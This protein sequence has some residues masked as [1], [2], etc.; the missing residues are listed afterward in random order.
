MIPGPC[1]FADAA[2]ALV[3]C[4]FRLRG[5][6]PATGIDCVGLVTCALT[7]IGRTPPR[8]PHYSL[9]NSETGPLLDLIP[10]AGFRRAKGTP[11]QGD[12]VVLQP[13]P[14]QLHLAITDTGTRTALNLIHAHA[15]LGRV[16]E[17]P[18]PSPLL[19]AELWRLT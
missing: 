17:T 2:R 5:R 8:L 10:K 13:S 4:R 16:V 14:G 12:L 18:A 9:R 3:G 11:C 19:Y 15:G 7:A 6:D 1:A